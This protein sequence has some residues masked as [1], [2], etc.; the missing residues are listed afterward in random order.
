MIVFIL[1]FL[2]VLFLVLA[3]AMIFLL[4]SDI[5]GFFLADKIPYIP[6]KKNDIL[7]LTQRL[8][9]KSTDVIVDLGCGDGRVLYF[10]EKETG[11]RVVGY[12][13][14]AWVY[15]LACWKRL[16]KKSRAKLVWGN[17]FKH[18]LVDATV[19]YCYLSARMEDVV[20]KIKKECRPGTVVVSRDFVLP[21]VMQVDTV[22]CPDHKFLI[23]KI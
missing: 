22:V 6:T 2:I 3:V 19:V 21:D 10:I 20:A 12:E 17:F 11:A 4:G 16:I 5:W 23:Y 9:L 18:S 13:I 15:V 8:N 14:V 7:L 1:I